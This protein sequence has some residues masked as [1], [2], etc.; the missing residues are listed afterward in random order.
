M[1]PN[2]FK[3]LS[4]YRYNIP[5]GIALVDTYLQRVILSPILFL[6]LSDNFVKDGIEPCSCIQLTKQRKG[7]KPGKHDACWCRAELN[8]PIILHGSVKKLGILCDVVTANCSHS[9][10]ENHLVD[11]VE[12]ICD[13]DWVLGESIKTRPQ[14]SN[15]LRK[16]KSMIS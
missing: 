14:I 9:E 8:G 15:K 2:M 16:I 1:K 11:A 10:L 5:S 4:T 12:G 6:S 7:R 3:R 13:H